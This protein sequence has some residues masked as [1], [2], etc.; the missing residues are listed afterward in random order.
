M[1]TNNRGFLIVELIVAVSIMSVIILTLFALLIV[2]IRG[3]NNGESS[4]ELNYNAR[5]TLDRLTKEIR[6]GSGVEII[7]SS[8]QGWLKVYKSEDKTE[9][10]TF[11]LKNNKLFLG[12]NNIQNP[13]SEFSNYIK[14]F[15]I[16]YYPKG[17]S[18]IN[19]K[20]VKIYLGVGDIRKSIYLDTCVTFRTI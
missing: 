12:L 20:G 13:N 18:Q 7:D 6:E 11:R 14:K 19:A 4:L 1:K 17:S 15:R 3:W 5:E 10:V 2:S 8:D 9:F 16:E